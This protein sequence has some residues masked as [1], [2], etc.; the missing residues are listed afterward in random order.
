VSVFSVSNGVRSSFNWQALAGLLVLAAFVRLFV[1]YVW[2]PGGGFPTDLGTFTA[3]GLQLAD[4]GSGSFYATAG[5]ADYPPAYLFVLWGLGLISHLFS[6]PTGVMSSLIKLPAMAADLGIGV[7]LA[8]MVASVRRPRPDA[9]RLALLAAGL[10]LFNPLTIYDSAL[11]GQ[12]DSVGLLVT[13]LCVWTLTEGLTEFALP[14]AMLAGLIKPQFGLV[15]APILVVLLLCRHVLGSRRSGPQPSGRFE[16]LA[17]RPGWLRIGIGLGALVVVYLVLALP[18]GLA[19]GDLLNLFAKAA[20]TY[21]YLTVNAYNPWALIGPGGVTSFA[22]GGGWIADSSALLG[23][24]SAFAIGTI[25]MLVG[26]AIAGLALLWRDDRRTIYLATAIAAMVFFVAPTRVHERYLFPIVALLPLLAI[27]SRRYLALLCVLS[28]AAFLNF[29][30]VLT[31]YATGATAGLIGGD[32]ARNPALVSLAA[33]VSAAGLLYLIVD[34]GLVRS[35]AAKLVRRPTLALAIGDPLTM[36][37][38]LPQPAL[39]EPAAQPGSAGRSVAGAPNHSSSFAPTKGGLRH[40]SS[41]ARWL[42]GLSRRRRNLA[43]APDQRFGRPDAA[44][45]AALVIVALATRIVGLGNPA[46]MYFDEVYHARTA[47]EFL[48]DWRYGIPHDIYEFTHPHL[49][50]YAMAAGITLF[51]D[52]K[53]IVTGTLTAPISSAVIEPRYEDA[54][55]P[56]A[57]HGERLY[58]ATGTDIEAFAMPARTPLAPIAFAATNLAL[59]QVNH[60]LFAVDASGAL[61]VIPTD[62]AYERTPASL[63]PSI[64][65]TLPA[66]VTKLAVSS[67]GTSVFAAL[68]A[69]RLVRID[70]TSGAI[71]A[72]RTF[73]SA[74]AAI[75]PLNGLNLAVALADK[76]VRPVSDSLADI[77][78]A[79]AL[80]GAA[81]DLLLIGVDG[82]KLYAASPAGLTVLDYDTTSS[83]LANPVA[84]PMPGPVRQLALDA[85]SGLLHALGRTADGSADTVYVIEPHANAVFADA[86]LSFDASYLVVDATPGYPASDP[87]QALAIGADGSL[88]AIDA[89]SNAFAWRLPGAII[90]SLLIGALYLLGRLVLR[91]RNAAIFAG[92]FAL[93]D[94][95]FFVSARIAMND[96]YATFF[97]VAAYALFAALWM[98]CWRGKAAAIIGL[99]SVGLLLGLA[100]ASKWVGLYAMAAIAIMILVR[101]RIGRWLLVAGLILISGVLGCA[102]LFEGN[103]V[104]SLVMLVLSLSV[105]ALVARRGPDLEPESSLPAWIRPGPGWIWAILC[106]AI[107]PVAV[108]IASYAPWVALG[109][110]WFAG[111]PAGH[112]GQTLLALQQSMY[113]YH[114]TLRATHP[115]SSPWWAWPLDLKPVW[116]ASTGYAGNLVGQIY[117]AGNL[118]VFA[119][120]IPA[121]V[122]VAGAARKRRDLG[123]AFIVIAFLGAWLPWARIDRATFEYHFFSALPFAVLALGALLGELRSRASSWAFLAAK[124]GAAAAICLPAAL[125]VLRS[126]LCAVSGASTVA[127]SSSA[128]GPAVN[129]PLITMGLGL[130]TLIFVAAAALLMRS[131]RGALPWRL[132]LGGIAAL[133]VIYLGSQAPAGSPFV[134]ALIGLA[135]SVSLA[136]IVISMR[137]PRLLAAGVLTAAVAWS[138]LSYAW[139]SATP[140]PSGLS[141]LFDRILPTYDYYFQFATNTS[142]PVPGPGFLVMGICTLAV[143]MTVAAVVQWLNPPKRANE[144]A[145]QD[146][147]EPPSS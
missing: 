103:Y 123:F 3:W 34:T 38:Y 29:H 143:G 37:G 109:N 18:F 4:H 19:P 108:Y 147:E 39:A 127:A 54:N 80:P 142:A 66:P 90:G 111:V 98:G 13:L 126:P 48:Q 30:G 139:L 57:H 117:D 77:G 137:N 31:E 84:I 12:V 115:A 44:I 79:L 146:Q 125:W 9:N 65:A 93:I 106:L 60:R 95:M 82:S 119:M 71:V 32:L 62:N 136:S 122:W 132:G 41:L 70:A 73:S 116:F 134:P 101:T 135:G 130:L 51:G 50:K 91:R 96:V 78:T 14:L 42:G 55:D 107:V 89:G 61:A 67:D 69:N 112:S 63:T 114:D 46:T 52:N 120:A 104:F 131:E 22:N 118:V 102:A 10:Y 138:L 21:P 129:E 64:L 23:G 100:L 110:Q 88:A 86:R 47:T 43:P 7:I 75:A 36:P 140:I 94:G 17:R 133:D 113:N 97:I 53:V 76:S 27:T 28:G 59:D 83:T 6:D 8:L 81:S 26:L 35:A 1:A 99:P 20:G 141:G 11:W 25:A 33:L 16:R 15:L 72:D 124:L 2:L 58:I 145:S 56:T 144:A 45:A 74:I 92:L 68:A 105:A 128:C 5:F 40:P 87:Q 85:S 121:L 49:A 24:L